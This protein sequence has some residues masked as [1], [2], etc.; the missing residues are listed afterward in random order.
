MN[1][2]YILSYYSSSLLTDNK[3]DLKLKT[4][5]TFAFFLI[6]P[7]TFLNAKFLFSLREG[8]FLHADFNTNSTKLSLPLDIVKE[9]QDSYP[10]ITITAIPIKLAKANYFLQNGKENEAIDLAREGQKINPYL[11]FGDYIIS[12]A[13]YSKGLKDSSMYYIKK[14]YDKVPLNSAHVVLYQNLLTKL[15][16]N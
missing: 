8:Y 14:S 6:V 15:S 11:G 3:F 5:S 1:F 10:N 4:V 13:Y 2:I 9:Y 7:I 12:K 16:K